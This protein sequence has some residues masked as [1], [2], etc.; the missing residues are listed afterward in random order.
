[1]KYSLWV[2]IFGLIFAFTFQANRVQISQI[3]EKPIRIV[4]AT[5]EAKQYQVSGWQGNRAKGKESVLKVSLPEEKT[6]QMVIKAFSCSPPDTR[7]QRIEVYF[8]NVAL[9]RLKFRKTSKWQE[10][11][12]NIYPYLLSKTNTIK[13]IYTQD[14]HLSPVAF[15]SLEF[16]NCIFHIKGLYLLFDSPEQRWTNYLT[17]RTLGYSFG[18]AILLWFFWLSY[19]SFLSAVF[20]I[21][22]SRALRVDLLNYLPSI[23]LLSIFTCISFFSPY[24]YIYSL[25]TFFILALVPTVALKAFPCSDI[26]LHFLLRIMK[27]IW[28]TYLFIFSFPKNQVNIFKKFLIQYH[29]ANLSSAFILDFMLLLVLCA[30]LLMIQEPVAT[31]IAEQFANLAYFLLV[32]GVIIKTITFFRESRGRKERK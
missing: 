15:D 2:I 3:L 26:V 31:K 27:R 10:F 22:F 20:K 17:S 28:S 29:K 1:M 7:D 25:P 8:N 18:L 30:F 24:H 19:S 16:K 32:I 5:K 14:T 21:K 13:F 23:T 6:Y 4:P 11:R 12:I 9:D